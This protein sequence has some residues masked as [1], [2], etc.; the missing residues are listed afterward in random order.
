MASRAWLLAIGDL[1]KRMAELFSNCLTQGTFP[2]KWKEAKLILLR[3]VGRPVDSISAYRPICLINEAGKIFEKVIANRIT[4][5]MD[6][7]GPQLADNQYGFRANRSTIDAILKV[8]ATINEICKKGNIALLSLDIKNAFNTL[9][10]N[11][12]EKTF[13]HFRFPVYL[14]RT[15][16]DYFKDR[17]IEYKDG[18]GVIRQ[19]QLSCGVP[20]G[21]LLGLLLWDLVYDAILR[22]EVPRGSSLIGYADDTLLI[23]SGTTWTQATSAADIAIARIKLG[24]EALGLQIEP[25]K[26]E[27]VFIYNKPRR[28]PP[29]PLSILIGVTRVPVGTSVKYLGLL[30]DSR[31]SF[32]PHFKLVAK[33][34]IRAANAL[35]RLLPNRWPRRPSSATI[36]ICN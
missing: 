26:T 6:Q 22:L 34:S 8:R 35:C 24:I 18:A 15:L 10:W 32:V 17:R 12:L 20:Q 5:H 33:K 21:S 13:E 25:A 2:N 36:F 30:I 16:I 28:H 3:K 11:R 19:H 31:W 9:P 1:K 14:R 29:L 27:A 23:I 7:V 4:L